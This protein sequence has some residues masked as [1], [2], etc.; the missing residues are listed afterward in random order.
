MIYT[1]E[2]LATGTR[3]IRLGTQK[4]GIFIDFYSDGTWGYTL[5]KEGMIVMSQDFEDRVS[6]EEFAAVFIGERGSLK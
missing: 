4:D 1:H 3:A 5:I 2:N 6:F